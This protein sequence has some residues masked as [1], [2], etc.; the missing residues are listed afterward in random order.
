MRVNIRRIRADEG[1]LLMQIRLMA[2]LDAPYAFA[3]TY[4]ESVQRPL[5]AWNER[6]RQAATGRRDAVFLAEGPTDSLGLVGAY[7][8]RD[9]SIRH[10]Y[11]L[12]IDQSARR[13]GLACALMEA[14]TEWA[15]HAGARAITLWV[16]ESN[17]PALSLYRR[18]G[19]R[20]TGDTQPMPSSET[21]EERL[22]RRLL[23]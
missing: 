6:A 9:T 3:S 11:G 13:H 12:W 4:A 7:T 16:A 21:V 19:F 14:V 2:L 1:R 5:D 10:V 8:P 23:E 18:L 17:E 15:T 22:L 20:E